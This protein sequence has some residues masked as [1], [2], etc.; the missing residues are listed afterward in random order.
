M[1]ITLA[2]SR[3]TAIDT[4]TPITVATSVEDQANKAEVC[5]ITP[6]PVSSGKTAI[7]FYNKHASLSYTAT[8]AAGNAYWAGK[9]DLALTITGTADSASGFTQ[10]EIDLAKYLN[11][12]GKVVITLTPASGKKLLTDHG[13]YLM[14]V[15]LK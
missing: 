11:T 8:I 1:A 7:I 12:S 10:V 6:T 2:S 13:S 4:V 5:T 14:A 9:K 15:E 3:I